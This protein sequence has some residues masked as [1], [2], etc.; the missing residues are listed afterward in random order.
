MKVRCKVTSVTRQ[1]GVGGMEMKLHEMLNSAPDG[2]EVAL[3]PCRLTP[4]N[5][6]I[7]SWVDSSVEEKSLFPPE[8]ES[9]S[10]RRY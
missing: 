2:A 1:E 4:G 10:T 3:R 7:R 9:R 8:A 6:W 5:H